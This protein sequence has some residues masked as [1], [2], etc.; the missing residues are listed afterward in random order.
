MQVGDG[1]GAGFV[2]RGDVDGFGPVVEEAVAAEAVGTGAELDG[3]PLG[4][5]WALDLVA[6]AD[7]E[8]LGA[9]GDGVGGAVWRA[10]SGPWSSAAGVGAGP[11]GPPDCG[12]VSA[13]TPAPPRTRATA[14]AAST[15][16]RRRDL[17]LLRRL[18]RAPADLGGG[19][20]TE[21]G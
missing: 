3:E 8:V 4:R 13:S 7:G 20:V 16:P 17:R 19:P 9:I 11:G 10:A 21:P 14:V 2:G 5:G 6:P 12:G 1:D 15:R 18:R